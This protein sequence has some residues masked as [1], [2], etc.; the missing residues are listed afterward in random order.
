M[1]KLFNQAF[2]GQNLE[3][4]LARMEASWWLSWLRSNGRYLAPNGGKDTLFAIAN[5]SRNLLGVH[6]ELAMLGLL[7]GCLLAGIDL[8]VWSTLSNYAG[9]SLAEA[10]WLGLWGILSLAATLPTLFLLL[11]LLGVLAGAL[12]CAYWLMP[13]SRYALLAPC[14]AMGLFGAYQYDPLKA[15]L[16]LLPVYATILGAAFM[17]MWMAGAVL[18]FALCGPDGSKVDKARNQVT[19]ALG[20]VLAG[21]VG[22]V[23]IGWAD[24]LAWYLSINSSTSSLG[25][26]LIVL[27]VALRAVLPLL[28]HLPKNMGPFGR[29]ALLGLLSLVGLGVLAALVVFWV[30]VVHGLVS[31]VVF[32]GGLVAYYEGGFKVL[33]LLG[34]VAVAWA[35]LTLANVDFLNRSSLQTFYRGRLVRAYLGASTRAR[36]QGGQSDPLQPHQPSPDDLAVTLPVQADDVP[37][38]NYQPHNSGGPVHLLNVCINQT[39]DPRGGLFNS[40]R[41]GEPMVVAPG[42]LMRVAYEG[43][44]RMAPEQTMTLGTWMAISGAAFAPG[45]GASTRPGLATLLTLAGVRLGYWWDSGQGSIA[46]WR[47][48]SLLWAELRGRFSGRRLRHW[49]LSDGGHFDNTGAYALLREQCELIVLAD[50]GADPTYRFEDLESLVRKARI[51]L[52]TEIVFQ[53]PTVADCANAYGSLADVAANDSDACL[54]LA[55]VHYRA[56]GMEGYLIIV[57][58]NLSNTIPVDLQNFKLTNPLFPQESTTDQFFSEAQWESYFQLGC[59]LGQGVDLPSSGGLTRHFS[60]FVDDDGAVMMTGRDGEKR[61]TFN[62]GR[63]VSRM[64]AS[65]A[66]G[67]T[68]S[69][70]ALAS[71]GVAAWQLFEAQMQRANASIAIDQSESNELNARYIMASSQANDLAGWD[72]VAAMLLRSAAQHCT[73]PSFDDFTRNEYLKTMVATTIQQCETNRS[74]TN[75]THG[76]FCAKMKDDAIRPSCLT[77]PRAQ[78]CEARYWVRRYDGVTTVQD[79]CLAVPT[80]IDASQVVVNASEKPEEQAQVKKELSCKGYRVYI[81]VFGPALESVATAFGKQ[82]REEVG[83]EVPPTEDVLETAL[84]K[85]RKAPG[86]YAQPTI[87]KYTDE[88]IQAAACARALLPQEPNEKSQFVPEVWRSE[89]RWQIRTLASALNKKVIEVWFPAALPPGSQ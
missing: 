76:L 60:Q 88:D 56:T 34:G 14:A 4:M 24:Q 83:A 52:D 31:P 51:D 5:F 28:A 16:E 44:K 59:R 47:K 84:R 36:F 19:R 80:E 82:W 8:F 17:G 10:P 45:L 49:Y 43:W 9:D 73:T 15:I 61:L 13:I 12:S 20:Y 11:P 72:A 25:P 65:G 7:L 42:G 27:G 71:A 29:D 1:G 40:D 3:P 30:S 79:N 81:Q 38:G 54:A 75:D 37:L 23:L 78:A 33:Y 86:G 68:L 35:L 53:R 58:P 32:R 57:K 70:G 62:G 66:V 69:L 22:C 41:K 64:V 21:G 46:F 26:G 87:I 2:A 67:A 63:R 74:D 55:K 85:G 77:P 18:A 89:E 48:Y 50:C 39:E 6:L